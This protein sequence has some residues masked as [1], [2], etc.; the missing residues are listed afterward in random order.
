M[1]LGKSRRAGKRVMQ[2]VQRFLERTLKLRIN[3]DKSRVAPTGQ[4][5]FLGFTF[6]GVRIRW[7]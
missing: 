3:Q 1:I 7:T 2:G 5:T 4:A 6:R